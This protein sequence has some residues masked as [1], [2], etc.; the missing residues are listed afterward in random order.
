MNN[1]KYVNFISEKPLVC[2]W[3]SGLN[4]NTNSSIQQE[5]LPISVTY[6]T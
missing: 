3:T 4:S 6:T 1:S 2:G 5:K